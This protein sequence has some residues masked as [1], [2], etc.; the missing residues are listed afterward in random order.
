M[1]ALKLLGQQ[2]S[3]IWHQ[4]GLN[5][6]VVIVVSGLAVVAG[7]SAL[8]FWS[9]RPS[10]SLLFGRLAQE[11][12][13]K[14]ITELDEMKI[15]N[16]IGPNGSSIYVPQDKV[17]FAR[18]QLATKGI[19]KNDG[20]GFEIFD[21]QTFG[22]SDFVQNVNHNRAIEGELARTIKEINGVESARVIISKPESRL[23]VDPLKKAKASVLVKLRGVAQLEGNSVNA[24]RFL[25][26]SAVEGLKPADVNVVD[27]AG[28]VLSESSEEGSLAALSST[29]LAARRNYEKYF[30]EK[31][32]TMLD[33]MLGP[34]QAVVAISVEINTETL[35]KTDEVYDPKQFTPRTEMV[36]DERVESNTPTP[37]GVP[38]TP[39]NAN[40]DT[41][42]PPF[43]TTNNK[44]TKNDK[45]TE[46]AVSK[47]MTN[48]VRQ[49][50][51]I[52][53]I[54]AAVF[55]NT[56]SNPTIN[57]NLLKE[58]VYNALGLQPNSQDSTVAEV[59]TVSGY[60][61]NRDHEDKM[62]TEMDKEKRTE[63]Y[64]RSGKSALYALLAVAA[65]FGFWRLVRNSTEELL[66]TGIPVGQLVGGQLVYE[67][68]GGMPG[69]AFPTGA[70]QTMAEGGQRVEEVVAAGDEDVEELQAAKSKLVMDFGLGQQAPERITI[71][72]LKQLIRENPAK[73]SQA[74]RIWMTRKARE[75]AE[76]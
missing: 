3:K 23:L 11:E 15:P 20:V 48:I 54:S 67:S 14:V 10:Y 57:T 28:N 64:V 38:G 45:T 5:Q 55:V 74:A 43:S 31:V 70:M 36:K 75:S 60:A 44:T 13:G 27:N 49:A 4:L 59:V 22:M 62:T 61:F 17:H 34:D 19:P 2:L 47:S 68:P 6:K 21:K 35:T 30:T 66:P 40:T 37:G 51:D 76:S 33:K 12:A 32:K 9:S 46:Y 16:K 41:N 8:I 24:I 50:G 52:K 63:F 53:K 42:A 71:E 7:L 1:Q 72:V 56:A 29:Q 25:V 73:M 39:I 26:S 65:L 69:M 58:G 18:M